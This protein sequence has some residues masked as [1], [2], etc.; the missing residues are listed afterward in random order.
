MNTETTEK[1]SEHED[2]PSVT[3]GMISYNDEQIIE[4][5]L[6][7]IRS[8]D[9]DQKRIEILLVDG[10]SSDTTLEIAKN[11]G[12]T[13]V[14]RPDLKDQSHV[15]G[16]MIP[17][18]S[19]TDLILAF[20]ADNR[21]QEPDTLSKMVDALLEDERTAGC[22]TLRYGYRP[23]DPVLSRY[24]A[25]IGGCDPVAVGLGKADRGPYDARC[26]HSFG[27]PTDCGGF[28]KVRFRDD[29]AKIPTLGANGFLYRR[30]FAE[31]SPHGTQSTHVDLCVD[32]IRQG[33]DQFAFIKDRHVIH[34][35][36]VGWMS[37]VKRRLRYARHYSSERMERSY[38]VYHPRDLLRLIYIILFYP[39]F[40]IPLLR[41][42][43][44][45]MVV[46]D[47]AWFL[48][49]VLCFIFTLSYSL[50][51]INRLFRSGFSTDLKRAE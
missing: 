7:S 11:Y 6:V 41:A 3:V 24:F 44:G 35:I 12:A 1:C 15:R 28:L 30:S 4:E 46:R 32:W 17:I 36:N 27:E 18:I 48:H 40:V 51:F 14:S 47:P 39:T 25:L 49:P 34:F 13:V 21:L 2:K 5:C 33:Y 42:L 50:H 37:F 38:S 26:W 16:G 19:K 23:S 22:E 10:G 29:T 45:Y 8:Q 43:R 9:Y 20:S 31:K